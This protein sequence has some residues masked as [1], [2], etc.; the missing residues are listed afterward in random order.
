MTADVEAAPVRALIIYP[1]GEHFIELID[2]TLESLRKIVGGYI[3]AVRLVDCHLYCNEVGK[4]MNLQPNP[5]ATIFARHLRW[6][7][8]NDDGLCGPVI[9]LG[10]SG[11]GNEASLPLCVIES[12]FALCFPGEVA[13]TLVQI[14]EPPQQP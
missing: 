3:E 6:R 11:D 10:D 2:P 12:F 8:R 7:P 9:F 5:L 1:D 14:P 4:L 13:A